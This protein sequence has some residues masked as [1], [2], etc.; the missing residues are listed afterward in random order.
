MAAR[1]RAYNPG[2]ATAALGFLPHVV[3]GARALRRSGRMTP[4]ATAAAAAGALGLSA[5]LPVLL[6]RRMRDA[7]ATRPGSA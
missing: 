1:E 3:L 4:R 5:G 2:V 7:A 6:R